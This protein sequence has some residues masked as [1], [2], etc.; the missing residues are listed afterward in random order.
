MKWLSLIN[1][2]GKQ[3]IGK[4]EKAD[5]TVIVDDKSRLITGVK[6][7]QDGTPY[8]ITTEWRFKKENKEQ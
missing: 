8:L 2:L 5:V 4:L 7:M 6:F 3:T 1:K